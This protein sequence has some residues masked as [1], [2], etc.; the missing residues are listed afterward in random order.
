[1]GRIIVEALHCTSEFFRNSIG[2]ETPGVYGED[3][4]VEVLGKNIPNITHYKVAE[5]E[6]DDVGNIDNPRELSRVLEKAFNHFNWVDEDFVA[7]ESVN[8]RAAVTGTR[9]SMTAGDIIRIGNR[10]FY[11]APVGW[12][13]LGV[14]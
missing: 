2:K 11:C 9:C 8:I 7:P 4:A 12:T 14:F 10:Y 6:M 13:T 5:W 1:M 3:R